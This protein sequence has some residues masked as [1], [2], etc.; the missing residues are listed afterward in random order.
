[1][2]KAK[3]KTTDEVP[4]FTCVVC[5]RIMNWQQ[6]APIN[7][8]D[9]H[10]CTDIGGCL[11]MIVTTIPTPKIDAPPATMEAVRIRANKLAEV[12]GRP[13]PNIGTPIKGEASW[14]WG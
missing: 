7:E 5:G 12:T 14:Y 3:A 10:V 13:K 9:A 4:Q 2:A 1:M 11:A 8:T 6:V